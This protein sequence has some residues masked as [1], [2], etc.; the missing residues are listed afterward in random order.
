MAIKKKDHN[1]QSLGIRFSFVSFPGN[2]F[3]WG[4]TFSLGDT[5]SAF[6]ALTSEWGNTRLFSKELGSL[7]L[8]KQ[9]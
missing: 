7:K 4:L 2:S 3:L 6:E 5:I 9:S 1:P 8:K